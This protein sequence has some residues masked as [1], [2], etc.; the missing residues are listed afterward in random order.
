MSAK[1][2]A[3]RRLVA[4]GA[5]I[6]VLVALFPAVGSAAVVEACPTNLPSA[7][8]KDL[9]GL[10]TEAIKAIDCITHYGI[11]TGTSSTNFSPAGE[12]AR[13]QMA[14]FLVR[15]ADDLGIV[16][17]TVT[18]TNF[19]DINGYP[20][21]TQRAINQLAQMGITS[22]VAPRKFDPAG[23]VPRWQM[24]LF[25]TRMHAKA[26]YTL[27]SGGNM[28]FTDIVTY[29]AAT[30]VAINQLAQLGIAKGTTKTTFSPAANVLRWQMA[31]FLGRQLQAGGASPYDI[32][33]SLDLSTA[34]TSNKVTV[35]VTV[36]T[37]NGKPVVGRLV[38]IFVGTVDSAGRCVLDTDAKIGTGDAGTSTNCTID[39]DDP[40]TNS[41]GKVT[42]ELTHNTTV[43]TDRVF[44]WIGS[45]GQVFDTDDVSLF[46]FADVVWTA[47]PAKIVVPSKVV[48]FGTNT[49]VTGWLADSK[50]NVVAAPGFRI[51]VTV[52]RSGGQIISQTL[53]T[54]VNGRFSFSYTGPSDPDSGNPSA[55]IVDAV[56]AFWDKNGNGKDDGSA[57]FDVTSTI[58]WDDDDPRAD[59]AV[60]GQSSVTGLAGH[61]VTLTATVKDKFGTPIS[62]ASVVFT[63]TGAN[64]VVK[65]PVTT[66]GSGVATTS[67]Q[68]SNVGADTI[69]AAV[70][71][72]G[73]GDDILGSQIADLAHYTVEVAPNINGLTTYDVLAV[74]TSADT[75]DVATG[76]NYYRLSYDS[77]NDTYSINGAGSKSMS[78]FE[79]A[80]SGLALPAT[81]KLKTNPYAATTSAATS[82]F[83]TTP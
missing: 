69:D 31:L 4:V 25:L 44:A 12:V 14:L 20:I 2:S 32:S 26:G 6:A 67:Y 77:N 80:L 41:S 81:G 59:T 7:G 47:E 38:D 34:P 36:L 9:G 35:T 73:G 79:A 22:G 43:E 23:V 75:I 27:P 71:V 56:K 42:V 16:V 49:T 5:A 78:E 63:I 83:L 39:K 30:Q 52:S 65:D 40:K 46:A 29:P 55:E 60:L 74:N 53:T 28:G 58:T 33:V 13:W 57:E 21:E 3:R 10:S 64:A 18:N 45:T 68:A 50:D 82:W 54:D 1:R 70:D 62:G 66:N 15:M 17:P 51:V 24:A 61:T 72:D 8:Y 76:G 48:K 19:D 11:A 37:P